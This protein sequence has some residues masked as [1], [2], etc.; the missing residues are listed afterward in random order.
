LQQWR[1]Q[2]K[3]HTEQD[4]IGRKPGAGSA[5]FRPGRVPARCAKPS[6]RS[7]EPRSDARPRGM[8]VL[9]YVAFMAGLGLPRSFPADR[10]RLTGLAATFFFVFFDLLD[11]LRRL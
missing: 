6:G 9:W 3:P 10:I 7:L 1:G 2:G 4:Q 5:S 11:S 8:V